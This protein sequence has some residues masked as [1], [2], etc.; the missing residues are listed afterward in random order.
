M[1]G[2]INAYIADATA[3]SH[4]IVKFLRWCRRYWP[5]GIFAFPVFLIL[6]WIVIRIPLVYIQDVATIPYFDDEEIQKY[7]IDGKPYL[8]IPVS[9]YG[10]RLILRSD[11]ID[12]DNFLAPGAG[13]ACTRHT[14]NCVLPEITMTFYFDP[15]RGD[16]CAAW[17]RGCPVRSSIKE[18]VRIHIENPRINEGCNLEYSQDRFKNDSNFSGSFVHI[19]GCYGYAVYAY[20]ATK[21]AK[22]FGSPGGFLERYLTALEI[23][24]YDWLD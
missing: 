6:C 12:N 17:Q 3:V 13:L 8:H 4:R 22:S 2:L 11:L 18:F 19:G 24:N 7:S 23:G 21:Y 16:F 20:G 14:E 15:K 5:L 10:R 1:I 9:F